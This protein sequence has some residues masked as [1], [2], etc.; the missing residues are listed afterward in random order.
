LFGTVEGVPNSR[1][2][3]DRVFA[4]LLEA[5]LG[6][7]WAPGE[8]LPGQ[9]AL[10]SELGVTMTALREALKRLEQMGLV[11]VRHGA[12]M[13]VA[14]VRERGTLDVLAPLLLRG[15]VVDRAV[16]ADVLE[17]RTL[18]LVELAGLAAERRTDAQAERLAELAGG[19][20]RAADV[21]AAQEVDF[22][23]V[24]ELA[25]AADNLVFIL[26]LNAIR[27]VYF[28]HAEQMPVTTGHEHLAALYTAA[29]A[30]IETQ[31]VETAR[32]ATRTLAQLQRAAVEAA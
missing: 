10:A 5:I 26:I 23:W 16:L 19:I 12:G 27:E 21:A 32:N 7:R 3:A 11:E 28:A 17:A 6:G 9:R 8:R 4:G 25:H 14:D 13:V 30:A 1:L 31:D 22:A 20:A 2:V 15:G 18:M 29:S 24:T